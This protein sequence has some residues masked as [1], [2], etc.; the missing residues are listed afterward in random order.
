LFGRT[1]WNRIV[2]FPGEK[3]LLGRIVPVTIV[4]VFRNSNLGELTTDACG[5]ERDAS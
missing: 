2:N 5:Q 4:K 1:T 3:N